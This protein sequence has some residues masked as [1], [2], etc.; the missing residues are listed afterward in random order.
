MI[1][2]KSSVLLTIFCSS[3]ITYNVRPIPTPEFERML[4][5]SSQEPV[6][7]GADPYVEADRQIAVFDASLTEVGVLA[8][9]ILI[10]NRG[11]Q[12]V[13]INPGKLLLRLPH[14]K[15]IAPVEARA[16]VAKFNRDYGKSF[17]RAAVAFGLIGAAV[18][19]AASSTSEKAQADRHLDYATKELKK[20]VIEKGGSTHGF[21]FF[22]L[23]LDAGTLNDST[24]TVPCFGADETISVVVKL[25]FAKTGAKEAAT[26]VK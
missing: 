22:I 24:L 20:V 1:G 3:C 23:P 26:L 6:A 9:Q 10:Q 16:V 2:V 8:V 21:V 15:E 5:R 13:L 19:I 12:P 14:G 25:P 7:V 17:D 11:E 4:V 18:A